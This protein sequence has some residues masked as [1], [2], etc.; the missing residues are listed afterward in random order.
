MRR[1]AQVVDKWL[2]DEHGM[3][4]GNTISMFQGAS[5]RVSNQGSTEIA[6]AVNSHQLTLENVAIS[7]QEDK[8]RRR[9]ETGKDV[10]LDL[11]VVEGPPVLARGIAPSVTVASVIL[12]TT[13]TSPHSSLASPD[14]QDRQ[15]Q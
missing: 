7:V 8:K 14:G 5:S 1:N 11:M 15:Q 9:Q 6:T 13:I 2:R 12:D 3:A 4:L 10:D